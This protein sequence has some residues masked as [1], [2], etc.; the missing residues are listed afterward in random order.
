VETKYARGGEPLLQCIMMG[1]FANSKDA[2]KMNG[3]KKKMW[4]TRR[5]SEGELCAQS[6]KL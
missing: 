5:F 1:P 3:I 4:T 2:A 6:L